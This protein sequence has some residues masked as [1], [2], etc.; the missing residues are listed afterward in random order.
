MCNTCGCSSKPEGGEGTCCSGC[1]MPKGQCQC[2]K[3]SAPEQESPEQG[4]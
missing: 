2:Q 1:N 3:P 4:E